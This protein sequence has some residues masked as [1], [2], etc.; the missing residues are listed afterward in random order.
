M[1]RTGF[2]TKFYF[3]AAVLAGVAAYVAGA[4]ALWSLAIGVAAPLAVVSTP[5]FLTGFLRGAATPAAG[6]QV[7]A[8]VQAMTG[9][10]FEDF[11][12]LAARSC[13]LPVIM[14]PLSGDWGVDL[15]VG[16]RPDRLAIQCKRQ[17]RP[18]GSGAVQEVVAGAPMH[19]CTRTMVVTNQSFTPAARKLADQHGCLLVSGDDL[20]LLRTAIRQATAATPLS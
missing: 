13:G 1:A 16:H 15:V 4:G 6:E 19:D 10:E 5:T 8:A 11:V 20:A 2:R 18:V 12:A 14:T 9:E 7:S 3:G 17:A